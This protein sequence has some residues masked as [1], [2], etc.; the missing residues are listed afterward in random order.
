V[1]ALVAP[2]PTIPDGV[3]GEDLQRAW[4]GESQGPF[5]GQPILLDDRTLDVLTAW[6]GEPASSAVQVLP[7]A[8]LLDGTWDNQPSWAI[9][10]FED[11]GPR[12]KVLEIDG[13]SPLR[14]EFDL[15]TYPLT[16]PISLTGESLLVD[17]TLASSQVEGA[18]NLGLL[19]PATATLNG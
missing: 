5:A 18:A 9:I 8:D 12:W 19:W 14:K 15:A 2:F 10:P 4:R 17:T 1:Y 7:K 6:W 13:Q 16:V 11:L 3:D